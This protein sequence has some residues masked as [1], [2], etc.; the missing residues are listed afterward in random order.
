LFGLCIIVKYDFNN[1]KLLDIII[2]KV[3]KDYYKEKL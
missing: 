3:N 1:K 2:Q